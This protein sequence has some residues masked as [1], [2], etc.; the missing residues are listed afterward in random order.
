[1][2]TPKPPPPGLAN[3]VKTIVDPRVPGESLPIV[4]GTVVAMGSGGLNTQPGALL[5]DAWSQGKATLAD[6]TNVRGT[7]YA[8]SVSSGTDV[9]IKARNANPVFNPP[10]T[11]TWTVQ[12]PSGTG[13]NITVNAGKSETLAPGL[14]GSIDLSSQASLTLSTG[15]YYLSGL[16]MNAQSSVY[17][18]QQSGPIIIY[19]TGTLGMQGAFLPIE[20]AADGGKAEPNLLLGYLGT[21]SVIVQSLFDGALIAPFATLTLR[22]VSGIHTGFFVASSINDVD[23]SAEVQYRLPTAVLVA[24]GQAGDAG[25]GDGS[26][27]HDASSD[28]SDAAHDGGG[29]DAGGDAMTPDATTS[30]ASRDGGDAGSVD[31]TTHDAA[32]EAG[33]YCGDGI[34]NPATE[35]CDDGLGTSSVRRA[36]SAKCQVLDEL[37]VAQ[38]GADGGLSNAPRSL[39]YGRHPVAVNDTTFAVAYLEPNDV[40]LSLSLATF[41]AKGAATGITNMFTSQSTI[42]DQSSPVLAGLPGNLYAAAW[43]DYG[44]DG[45]EL[46]VAV[47]IV[48]PSV[49]AT[50]APTFANVTTA[51]SQYDPDIIWTGSELVVAWADDSDPATEPDLRF[52]TFD[53]SFNPTSGEQTL[54]DTPDSEADVALAVFDG[55]WA[56]AWRDDANGLETIQVTAAGGG[57]QWSVG[58]AFLPAPVTAKPALAQLDATH[59]LVVYAVGL[60][61]GDSGVGNDSVIQV[62]VLST[63]A[64]GAVSGSAVP[65]L[66]PAGM[67]LDQSL[68][69]VVSMEGSTFLSW[70]TA[71]ALGSSNGEQLWVKSVGWNGASLDLT[72]MEITLPR[73]PQA[74]LGDQRDPALA[75]SGLIPGG[76]IVAGWDD[77]GQSLAEGEGQE[78]VVM[79]MIPVPVL[80][81]PGDGGP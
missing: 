6:R 63:A 58:P 44:G 50:A 18:K 45:D 1:M 42:V 12:Y 51:F 2:P 80:R 79:E 27:P 31:A 55:S 72:Q 17:L 36:C 23:P 78:D 74:N 68:P 47:R 40:P 69:N 77:F 11:L 81:L 22:D 35:E 43:S 7:L 15:T 21:S 52:R 53:S 8:S 10:S 39:A 13:S 75:A 30:D 76:A 24:A 29:T 71:A 19:I 61:T 41:G 32:P 65:A 26:A 73:W 56:A 33:G 14:Y 5:N 16:T 49:V 66:A 20:G 60:E 9:T 37:A 25:T 67:G 54:A 70:W 28:S 46:G 57:T 34:R 59:L 38:L 62:A 3:L 64:Q 48:N 4:S